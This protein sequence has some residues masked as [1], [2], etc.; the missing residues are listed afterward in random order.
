MDIF[1]LATEHL[2]LRPFKRADLAAFAT[3]RNHPEVARYQSWSSCT[4]GDA[5]AFFAEQQR[6]VFDTD[7]TWFQIAAERQLDGML[8]GDVAVHFFDDGRQ[9]EI[10]MTFDVAAQRQGYATE[11]VT[12]VVQ[13]LFD[14]LRKHRIVATVDTRNP[15]AQ[16]LLERQGFRREAHYH[17]NIYFKGAW[18]DEY[19]FALLRCE[20]L[21]NR[22]NAEQGA[23]WHR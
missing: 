5:A 12:R 4:D 22:K 23:L 18:R 9:A 13:V 2:V 11:A 6:L 21:V 1:P 17:K 7:G 10:G 19:L 15:R 16:Q 14:D 8:L 3:Y 20:W